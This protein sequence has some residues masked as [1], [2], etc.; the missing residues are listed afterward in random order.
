M[1]LLPPLPGVYVEVPSGLVV[2]L[3][4]FLPSYCPS[5]FGLG[6]HHDS[7]CGEQ[8][9]V[10][11]PRS[12]FTWIDCSVDLWSSLIPLLDFIVP[13]F[14]IPLNQM[15]MDDSSKEANEPVS[16]PYL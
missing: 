6:S 16:A 10:T 2:V 3:S 1:L 8:D 7:R 13:T 15:E 4:S 9:V 14:D 12:A 5:V 11:S